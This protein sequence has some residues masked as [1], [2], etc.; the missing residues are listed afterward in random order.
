[1]VR[2]RGV[3]YAA[4]HVFVVVSGALG[5]E[6]PDAPV[7]AV[8]AVE[9]AEDLVEWVAVGRFRELVGRHGHG[10]D[11]GVLADIAEVETG[12]VVLDPWTWVRGWVRSGVTKVEGDK[13]AI[14]ER[15]IEVWGVVSGGGHVDEQ[16]RR[17]DIPLGDRSSRGL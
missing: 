16:Q 13:P 1:M 3:E 17:E 5:T 7:D 9:E 14:M 4:V 11:G 10:D 6:L 2:E 15:R 8:F 12:F